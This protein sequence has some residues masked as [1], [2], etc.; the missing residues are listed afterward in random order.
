MLGIGAA[1]ALWFGVFNA[2]PDAKSTSR[3]P[4]AVKAKKARA[5]KRHAS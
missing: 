2:I 5:V 4:P 1:T 3:N